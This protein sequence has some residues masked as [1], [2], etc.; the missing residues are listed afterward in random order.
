MRMGRTMKGRAMHGRGN[1]PHGAYGI[2][3]RFRMAGSE[4]WRPA[5]EVYETTAGLVVRVEV[6]GIDTDELAVALNGD[7]LT[8]E[9][10][11]HPEAHTDADTA[12]QYHEV[13]IPYGPFRAQVR[14]PF[15]VERDATEAEYEH[16]FLTVRLP[17][18]ARVSIPV[19]RAGAV[20]AAE[21]DI[22]AAHDT[23]TRKG[24]N[25]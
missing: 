16:G 15:P 14:L 11:R 8:I 3:F 17:R 12:R 5:L 13:G 24:D 20:P 2:A 21:A 4:A 19:E 7:A 10:Q 1:D 6:A 23:T 9:G 25:A 18:A 22:S